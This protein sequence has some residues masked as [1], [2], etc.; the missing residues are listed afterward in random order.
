M[1]SAKIDFKCILCGNKQHWY[2]SPLEEKKGSSFVHS[3]TAYKVICKH[4]GKT[5]ILKF[6][7]K[8]V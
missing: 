5:Y 7:I 3:L 8:A 4:C 6:N 1:F 2:I